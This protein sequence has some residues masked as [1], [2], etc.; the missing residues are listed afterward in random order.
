[1]LSEI[2]YMA[3]VCLPQENAMSCSTLYPNAWNDARR[4]RVAQQS[5]NEWLRGEGKAGEQGRKTASI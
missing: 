1:M 3:T 5:L 4:T 2:T